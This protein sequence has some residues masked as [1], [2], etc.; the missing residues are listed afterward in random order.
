MS[1]L[2]WVVRSLTVWREAKLNISDNELEN[3]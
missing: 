2:K 1:W 3:T